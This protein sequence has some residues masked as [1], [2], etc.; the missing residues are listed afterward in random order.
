MLAVGRSWF[1][2]RSFRLALGPA[3]RKRSRLAPGGALGGFQLLPQPLDFLLQ[4]LQ[5]L[6]QTL[7]LLLQLPDPPLG[8]VALLARAAHFLRQL[9]DAAQRV[10]GFE[11][12]IIL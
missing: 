12:Q 11:K 6:A 10:E 4:P 7:A 3:A 5:L 1:A 9:L 8:L 2:P